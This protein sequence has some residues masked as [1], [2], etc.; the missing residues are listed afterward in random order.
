MSRWKMP[1]L[2][3]AALVTAAPFAARYSATPAPRAERAPVAALSL[4]RD[5]PKGAAQTK[6]ADSSNPSEASARAQSQQELRKNICGFLQEY[7][8]DVSAKSAPEPYCLAGAEGDATNVPA[9]HAKIVI[10]ILPDPVHTHLALRF[11]RAIDSI[12]GALQRLGYTFDHSWLPWDNHTHGIPERFTDRLSDEALRAARDTTPG[13]LLF[14]RSDPNDVRPPLVLI[15]VGDTPTSGV[16][17]AQFRN[18]IGIWKQFA[19]HNIP[20]DPDTRHVAESDTAPPNIYPY[21]GAEEHLAI[22]GPTFSGSGQSLHRLIR[23]ELDPLA[24]DRQ[25]RVSVSSGTVSADDQLNSLETRVDECGKGLHVEPKSFN[26]DLLYSRF[27]LL[28]Y[29]ITR[30]TPGKIM[31]LVEAESTFGAIEDHTPED[32]ANRHI[33]QDNLDLKNCEP[34]D[35]FATRDDLRRWQNLAHVLEP[36]SHD[37]R[38]G[39]LHF[40]REISR[41]RKA[42]EQGGIVNFTSANS[43]PRTELAFSSGTDTRDD[44]TVPLFSGSEAD[45]AL[46]TQM[47]QIASLLRADQVSTVILS[48]TDVLDEIFVARF[49][50]QHTPDLT[51]IIQDAD[52]LFL[53]QGSDAI[54]N[55]IY[56][57]SPWPLIEQNQRWSSSQ[58]PQQIQQQQISIPHPSLSDQGI[59]YATQYLLCDPD[60]TDRSQIDSAPAP[61][62]PDALKSHS[63]GISLDEYQPPIQLPASSPID[64]KE[65]PPLWLSVIERGHFDPV[66]LIDVDNELFPTDNN[67]RNIPESSS[68]NLPR[69][70]ESDSDDDGKEINTPA[71]NPRGLVEDTALPSKIV[72]TLIFLLLNLHGIATSLCS[73]HRPFAWSYALADRQQHRVRIALQALL[74]LLAIPAASLLFIPHLPDL[75][76]QSSSFRLYL[77]II[78]F[79]AV[80]VACVGPYKFFR[81]WPS[82]QG[83]PPSRS[84]WTRALIA[85][86]STAAMG[87]LLILLCHL[88]GWTWIAPSKSTPSERIFFFYRSAHLL[89]GSSPALPLLLLVAALALW[90]QR[91]FGRLVFY[92]SRIPQVPAGFTHLRCPDQE[93]LEPITNL[94][95]DWKNRTRI[96]L[97]ICAVF[98]ASLMLLFAE[99][100]P[101]VLPGGHIYQVFAW[102]FDPTG[103]RALAHSSFDTW[104]TW[105]SILVASLILHDLSMAFVAWN[106]LRELCLVPLKQSPLRWGFT[107][108]KGFNWRRV[109]TSTQNLT[110]EQ[111]FD[112]LMRMVEA[113][114]RQGGNEAIS[115]KFDVLRERYY[116]SPK[117]LLWVNDVST[118][119]GWLYEALAWVGSLKLQVLEAHWH[120]DVGPVT[121]TGGANGDDLD[122]GLHLSQPLADAKTDT[123]RERILTRMAGEEFVALLYLAYIRMVLVQIRNRILT[124]ACLYVLLLWS[125]TSYPWMNR[126]AILLAL[127]VL[128]GFMSLVSVFIYSQMHRDQILSRTTETEPGKLDGGFVERLIP[129]IGIPLLTLVASQFPEVSN[130]VFSWLEPS[131]TKIQ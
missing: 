83:T 64:L 53:R 71:H 19:L 117:R 113:N 101:D 55:E 86:G 3:G 104:I 49:L 97:A 36:A 33:A 26:I 51:V 69:L 126:H 75:S 6:A 45:L 2:A 111:T 79:F 121:G 76:V 84:A 8:A 25:V 29:L 32:V 44:D 21:C 88:F 42:Y 81:P 124:A 80:F 11:D 119:I 24:A 85:V 110:P 77:W 56:V 7:V 118:A 34:A 122:R 108:I 28:D 18:A 14:R 39:V 125:L 59:Y 16:N 95:S 1:L 82:L 58:S 128:L 109:L 89:S 90:L 106:R 72:A 100:R 10:A 4:P 129:V 22:L 131:L 23:Q 37:N 15:V 65:Q 98:A 50:A 105:L 31:Q 114:E 123:D 66:A 92:G 52:Q 13:V 41:L 43:G 40:P 46:E 94:L 12:Q 30:N 87:L 9:G 20:A 47:S 93:R 73:L 62:K 17:N 78:Q 63:N 107:W 130:F 99:T 70:F 5:N 102:L 54:M 38:V 96:V 127:S 67:K 115:N 57:A 103:A 48:A 112:Y 27:Q 68:F 91:I 61:C 116:R 120:S 35:C 60:F 74:P